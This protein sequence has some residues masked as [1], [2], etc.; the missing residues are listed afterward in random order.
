MIACSA[1][2]NRRTSKPR[3]T[4]NGGEGHRQVEAERKLQ[5]AKWRRTIACA[6]RHSYI[7]ARIG[8]QVTRGIAWV[9]TD[10]LE[11]T[12]RFSWQRAA[13]APARSVASRPALSPLHRRA[14]P[15]SAPSQSP[16]LSLPPGASPRPALLPSR[17]PCRRPRASSTQRP[18]A[19]GS[20]GSASALPS[21][22]PVHR[23]PG[24][25]NTTP[26]HGEFDNGC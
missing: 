18:W 1:P 6:S 15:P 9:D 17:G 3:H 8:E 10:T 24:R 20:G 7:R 22:S 23:G 21:V 14:F 12:P 5:V 26:F 2:G 19:P 16:Q 25:E 4:R 11:T 13:T